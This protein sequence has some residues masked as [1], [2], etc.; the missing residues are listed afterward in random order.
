MIR[1]R[2]GSDALKSAT[3]IA[4]TLEI[5]D[6]IQQKVNGVQ[7]DYRFIGVR[8][9]ITPDFEMVGDR[10]MHAKPGVEFSEITFSFYLFAKRRDV[11]SLAAG[12]EV[13]LVY[14][15]EPLS[16]YRRKRTRV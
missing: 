6:D 10:L 4:K 8:K 7:V 14:L 11:R 15:R 16:A 3:R 5:I 2:N 13:G 9:I 1:I 12:R